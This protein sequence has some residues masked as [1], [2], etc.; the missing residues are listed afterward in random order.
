MAENQDDVVLAT[1][2]STQDNGLL[3]ILV[4]MFERESGRR[5][6]TVSVGTAD[7][8]AGATPAIG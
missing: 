1:T 8:H 2:T 7:L 6:K 4:P 5:V 3:D